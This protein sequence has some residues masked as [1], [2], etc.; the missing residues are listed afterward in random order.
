[1]CVC[2]PVRVK[3]K[4][5]DLVN[6]HSTSVDCEMKIYEVVNRGF[7]LLSDVVFTLC[8]SV[9]SFCHQG[10]IADCIP[11]FI[12]NRGLQELSKTKE[13]DARSIQIT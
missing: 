4:N 7:L 3:K 8:T 10:I 9:D 11:S 1:M 6:F 2:V 12:L 13:S 5:N